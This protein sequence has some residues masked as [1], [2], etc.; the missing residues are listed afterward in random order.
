MLAEVISV[1]GTEMTAVAL[2]WFVLVTTHSPARMGLV[3]A[4]EFAGISVLGIF[5]GR[6]PDMLGHRRSMLV[7]DALR[8][9]LVASIPV[10]YWLG[11]LRFPLLLLVACAVGA[12]FPAYTSSQRLV[13]ADL[14]GENELRL[15]RVGGLMGSFNETASFV[16]PAV[17]GLLVA[18]MGSGKVLLLDAASYLTAFGL[19]ALLV[20]GKRERSTMT[21]A[22]APDVAPAGMRSGFGYLARTRH[23]RRQVIGLG[24]NGIGFS[25][26]VA[27]MP[28][29]A[30]HA[31]AGPRLAGWYLAAY[32]AGSVAGGLIA[33]RAR[34]TGDRTAIY[35]MVGTAAS[36]W[37]MLVWLPPAVVIGAVAANGICSGLF[38]PRFFAALT[39]RTPERLRATVMTVVTSVMTLP[40]MIGFVGAGYLVEHTGSLMPGLL[41]MAVSHTVG[42][43]IV[44]A[45][46]VGD[47]EPARTPAL[48]T[49]HD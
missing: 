37:P 40:G 42:S 43:T 41:L 33:S 7:C 46:L 13:M 5:G 28:L 6:V 31:G 20:P 19:V 21:D 47:P 24:L 18:L 3:M 45:G 4:A 30:L 25:A 11:Q 16:G 14:V 2:P 35:A 48:N 32:G 39:L 22:D 36:T 9:P 12:F 34:R 27:S 8:A 17:G 26:M 29:L 49:S 15:T 44:V 10:L 23:L 1:T 38:Y